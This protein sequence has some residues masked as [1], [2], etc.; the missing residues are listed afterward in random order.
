VPENTKFLWLVVSGAPSEHWIH[1]AQRARGR[2]PENDEQ[3]PYQIKL[4]GTSPDE[5][6]V[7]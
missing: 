3:W 1:V 2:N 4:T 7:H 5:S 6:I